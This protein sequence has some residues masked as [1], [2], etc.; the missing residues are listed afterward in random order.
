MTLTSAAGI[1]AL[2]DDPEPELKGFALQNLNEVVDDFW[3]EI[4]ESVSKLEELH[5][6]KDFPHRELSALV[7]S[8][9]FYH[10]GGYEMSRDYA[11]GAG[12]LFD[13]SSSSEYVETIVGTAL[14]NM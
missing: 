7:V 3:A 14:S 2:L 13:I 10:L 1:L 11:L 6:D 8:K 5:E 12:S 4:S 9:V